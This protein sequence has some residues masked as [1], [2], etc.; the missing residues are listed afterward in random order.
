MELLITG[1]ERLLMYIS[2]LEE[3]C[4]D[5]LFMSN[6]KLSADRGSVWALEMALRYNSQLRAS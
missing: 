5:R 2:D 1:R 3:D 6:G 4:T